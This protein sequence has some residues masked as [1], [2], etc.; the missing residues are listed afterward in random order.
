MLWTRRSFLASPVALAMEG[1]T[2]VRSTPLRPKHFGPLYYD[3]SEWQMLMEVWK[4]RSPFRFWDFN[5]KPSMKVS[6]LEHEFAALM[7]VKYALAVNSGT[8]ALET[9]LAALEVGPGDEVIVPAWTWHSCFHAVVRAG[10]LPVCAEI[11][12]S[13]NLDPARVEAHIT[14]NTKVLMC[15]HLQGNPADMDRLLPLA[16][17][18]GLR[19]L[20]DVSQAV[21]ASYKGRRLG[22]MGDI[23]A[24]SMQVNKTISAGEGGMVY[25]NDAT[26]MERAVRFHDVGTLRG[27]HQEWLGQSK[28]EAMPGANF[29]MNEFTGGVLLA[30]VRKLDRI[31]GDIR[32]AARRVYAGIA[33][34]PGLKT[35]LLPDPAGEL[36]VGVYLDLGS[37]AATEKF[38]A[39]MKAENVPASGPSGSAV[40][41]VQGYAEK[42]LTVHP[43]WPS[44]TSARGKAIKYGAASCPRTLDILGRFGGVALDPR[45]TE[46]E[47]RDVVAAIRKVYPQVR[48]QIAPP[49]A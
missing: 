29:R 6:T 41:P 28:L 49:R 31:V 39:A 33:D 5:L 43:A 11:D 10:A 32:G 23:A 26:L 46:A 35:R 13:F 17:K 45:Y 20:E 4:T 37:H 34:L 3:D 48:G 27:P 1:G 15:V 9:A 21:G 38:L 24:A 19:V 2:P 16:R 47:T 30:Q 40:L 14:K 25:G 42:K 7:G 8:S 18:H 22:S 36:G 44:F 12:E